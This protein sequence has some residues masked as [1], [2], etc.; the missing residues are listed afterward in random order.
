MKLR[1][2]ERQWTFQYEAGRS[3]FQGLLGQIQQEIFSIYNGFL[4]MEPPNAISG[5][6][7]R[8]GS[9]TKKCLPCAA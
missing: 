6:L 1:L 8:S 2:L 7:E 3:A 4:G 5:F 9:S